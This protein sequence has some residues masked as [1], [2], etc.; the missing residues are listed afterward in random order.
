LA[1]HTTINASVPAAVAA[2]LGL[3]DPVDAGRIAEEAAFISAGVPGVRS[4]AAEVARRAAR[5][6]RAFE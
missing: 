1:G 2:V 5:I 6:A 4:T 3:E